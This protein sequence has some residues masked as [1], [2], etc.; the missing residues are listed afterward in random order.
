MWPLGLH[1]KSGHAQPYTHDIFLINSLLHD[2][3]I[4]NHLQ[5]VS[6]LEFQHNSTMKIP[7]KTSLGFQSFDHPMCRHLQLVSSLEFQL[8]STIRSLYMQPPS[9]RF[10][11]TFLAQFNHANTH[12][13]LLGFQPFDHPICNLLQL[14][15]SL[16]FNTIQSCKYPQNFT[17][18]SAI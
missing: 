5:L 6:S 17:W 8:N 1:T 13:T 10:F 9:I 11:I 4:Y 2:H 14:V 18:I 15:S 7:K 3:H 12:K 16:E